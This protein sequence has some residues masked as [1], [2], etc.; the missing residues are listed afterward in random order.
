MHACIELKTGWCQCTNPFGW[1]DQLEKPTP[2]PSESRFQA[3]PVQTSPNPKARKKIARLAHLTPPPAE[4]AKRECPGSRMIPEDAPGRVFLV[5]RT[6]FPKLPQQSRGLPEVTALLLPTPL[7]NRG[8]TQGGNCFVKTVVKNRSFKDPS[9][10]SAADPSC[11]KALVV[12]RFQW[13]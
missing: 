11:P 10:S 4:K 12:T 9:R 13:S 2:L 5:N 1:T 8:K 6:R 7:P 3:S